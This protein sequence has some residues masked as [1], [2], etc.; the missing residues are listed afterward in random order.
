[1]VD[2]Q[3][4]LKVRVVE[5]RNLAVRDVISSDPYV[6]LKLGTH[7]VKTRVIK[8]NLNPRWNEQLTLA[9]AEPLELLKLVVYDRDMLSADDKMGEAEIDLSSLVAAVKSKRSQD[10]QN[11]VIIQSIPADS[12]N[13]FTKDSTLKVKDGHIVQKVC[14]R[15]KNVESGDIKLELMWQPYTR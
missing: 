9:T 6:K 4:I 10:C 2:M 11:G 7:K 5:G 8:S 12:Q 13:C 14:I 15:L 1:M 3:G